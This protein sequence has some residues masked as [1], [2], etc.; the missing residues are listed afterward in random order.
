MI[1][2][3]KTLGLAVVVVSATVSAWSQTSAQLEKNVLARLRTLEKL[4]GRSGRD[5]ASFLE[6]ENLRLEKEFLRGLK[7]SST[8]KYP[9]KALAGKMFIATSPDGNFRIYSWDKQTGGTMRDFENIYQYR[10]ANRR[11]YAIAAKSKKQDVNGFSHQV[12]QFDTG[13][14]RVYLATFTFVLSTS[15]NRQE[16]ALFAIDKTKLNADVKLIKTRTGLHNSVGFDY[17]FFSV[18]NRPERP[19]TL[20]YFDQ[21]ARSFRFPVVLTDKQFPNGGRVTNKFITFRFSG[22]YF[23]KVT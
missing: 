8:L 11:V 5:N 13:K 1:K 9:F 23:T 12:F 15:A 10:G 14:G 20:F 6:K 7:Q 19:V 4:G 2:L 22:K 17:D 18:V 3:L 16:L 21:S